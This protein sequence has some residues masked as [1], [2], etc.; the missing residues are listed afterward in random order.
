MLCADFV[1][2]SLKP[3]Q[4][5]CT[6]MPGG[7]GFNRFARNAQPSPD[8]KLRCYAFYDRQ[9]TTQQ[10]KCRRSIAILSLRRTSSWKAKPPRGVG[11]ASQAEVQ[12]FLLFPQMASSIELYSTIW[13]R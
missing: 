2:A 4:L 9:P 5:D 7:S 1:S 3:R 12:G 6:S 11:L 13:L 10:T 8:N